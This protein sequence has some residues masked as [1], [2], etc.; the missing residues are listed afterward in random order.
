MGTT[1]VQ[2]AVARRTRV[3][4]FVDFAC[5][6]LALLVA[7]WLT[8]LSIERPV[9]GPVLIADVALGGLSCLALWLRRRWP[10]AVALALSPL[11]VFSVTCFGP[12]VISLF[13]VTVR[14][15]LAVAV[16][17]AVVQWATGLLFPVVRPEW[18]EDFFWVE[19]LVSALFTVAVLA[20]G[21]FVRTRRQLV[22][23]LRDRAQR[24]ESEQRLRVAQARR[25]ERTRIAREMHDVLTHRISLL[26][27]QARALQLRPGIPS[28]EIDRAAVVI[29]DSADQALRELH[30]VIGVLREEPAEGPPDRS[31]P[32]LADVPE[33]VAESRRAGMRVRLDAGGTDLV[34]VP[35]AVGRTAYRIVQEG[36]TNVRKHARG[37]AVVVTV[38]GAVGVG[39]TVE[40]RNPWPIRATGAI[41]GAGFG[42]VGLTE[43]ATLVGGR[44]EHGRTAV[45]DFRLRAWLPWPA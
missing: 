19:M 8:W 26:G 35:A 40:V 4:W 14:G 33:L 28:A 38:T 45:G 31:Q 7:G 25:M 34:A 22:V 21:L 42:L 23:S 32:T 27:R 15:R 43:R 1:S 6:G 18:Q 41:P 44:L 9:P 16:P 36:L 24:A 30:E 3:D 39:L 11:A 17:V 20:W 29:R 2:S 10:N 37:A 13:T 12:L 5:F